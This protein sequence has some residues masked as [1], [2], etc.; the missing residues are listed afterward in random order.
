MDIT[1]KLINVIV[2]YLKT[3]ASPVHLSTF[4]KYRRT[5]N[6]VRSFLFECNFNS[7]LIR[8]KKMD[9]PNFKCYYAWIICPRK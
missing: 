9:T 2:E 8:R 7:L 4:F 3:N 1:I 6:S 5:L